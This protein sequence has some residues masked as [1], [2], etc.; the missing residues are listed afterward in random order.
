MTKDFLDLVQVLGEITFILFEDVHF[1]AIDVAEIFPSIK[2]FIFDY[3]VELSVG[4]LVHGQCDKRI[5]LNGGLTRE[6]TRRKLGDY[7]HVPKRLK[8][9][10]K[11]DFGY[12]VFVS[13]KSIVCPR[14]EWFICPAVGI[15][16]RE[17]V[18]ILI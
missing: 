5:V 14:E 18:A 4:F 17:P 16:H 13:E 3:F 12:I 8:S 1:N 9:C 10:A 7:L 15:V 11:V 2:T 6:P